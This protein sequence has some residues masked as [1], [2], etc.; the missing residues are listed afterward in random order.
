MHILVLLIYVI[1]CFHH[2]LWFRLQGAEWCHE[3]YNEEDEEDDD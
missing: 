2:I 1:T 3:V